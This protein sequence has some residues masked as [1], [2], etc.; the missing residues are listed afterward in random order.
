MK[1]ERVVTLKISG[2][3][4]ELIE[5]FAEEM[6]RTDY[7]VA[8]GGKPWRLFS[9]KEKQLS[10]FPYTVASKYMHRAEAIFDFL[11]SEMEN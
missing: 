1:K 11:E 8:V 10:N 7:N 9:E 2:T 5:I 6:Y 4:K 3:R